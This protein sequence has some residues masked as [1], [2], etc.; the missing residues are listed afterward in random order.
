VAALLIDDGADLGGDPLRVRGVRVHVDRHV[1]LAKRAR[2]VEQQGEARWVTELRRPGRGSVDPDRH[3]DAEQ[4]RG[5]THHCSAT[6]PPTALRTVHGG[7][8]CILR[9]MHNRGVDHI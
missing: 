4:D 9:Q 1:G 2:A 7:T 6:S 3:E 8:G 5:E